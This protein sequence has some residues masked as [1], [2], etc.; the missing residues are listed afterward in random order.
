MTQKLN[1]QLFH[2]LLLFLI[3]FSAYSQKLVELNKELKSSVDF[4]SNTDSKVLS[5]NT[6]VEIG[7]IDDQAPFEDI[8]T[9]VQ[10]QVTKLD[11]FGTP[12]TDATSTYETTLKVEGNQVDKNKVVH[13]RVVHKISSYA[14]KVLVTGISYVNSSGTV[15]GNP[16][17]VYIKAWSE[18]DIVHPISENPNYGLVVA[19][20]DNN[21]KVEFRWLPVLGAEE[22]HLEWTWVDNYK[23]DVTD[24]TVIAPVA[25]PFTDKDFSYNN[26]RIQ[27]KG[28][29]YKI[30][31]IYNSGYVLARVR[32]VGRFV[33]NPT[34]TYTA[35][36]SGSNVAKS[37][38]AD[39]PNTAVS[40]HDESRKNWQLQMSFA[41]E[42]KKK[43][44]ISY[45]DGTLRNRQTVTKINSTDKAVVGEVIYDYQGRPAV[46]VLPVPV[47][48]DTLK[49]YDDFNVNN[50]LYQNKIYCKLNWLVNKMAD[51]LSYNI[52][53]YF[54]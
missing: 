12:Q 33:D 35:N 21:S 51:S 29:S 30:P 1:V 19:P 7:I 14:A 48:S 9:T 40:S 52:L 27:T 4:I 43:E 11:A 16:G 20:S 22:Y 41:E 49:Y 31:N 3:G 42:G 26:S 44:V 38:V 23:E 2:F 46:E 24:A 36:W 47:A 32:A 34:V 8:T 37:T 50:T 13:D 15:E 6:F 39:W 53:L 10:L 28:T 25:L 17:N 54:N 5:Y 45:F 18:H